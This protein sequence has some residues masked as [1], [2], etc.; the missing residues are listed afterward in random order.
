MTEDEASA[1]A[2]AE[3]GDETA[4]LKAIAARAR[5]AADEPMPVYASAEPIAAAAAQSAVATWI[6][7]G[8]TSPRVER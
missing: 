5:Q 4:R 1:V 7:T 3:T 2:A 6:L 8:S